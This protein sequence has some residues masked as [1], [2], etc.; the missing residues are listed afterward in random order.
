MLFIDSCQ[1]SSRMRSGVASSMA[2][3]GRA[4]VMSC[5]SNSDSLSKTADDGA[6]PFDFCSMRIDED[7][8]PEATTEL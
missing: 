3:K 6:L 2:S 7:T 8:R 5:G 1:A 4:S